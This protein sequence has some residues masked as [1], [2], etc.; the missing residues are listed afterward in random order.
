MS[1]PGNRNPHLH[2]V[3]EINALGKKHGI[4]YH[5][6]V[7]EIQGFIISLHKGTRKHGRNSTNEGGLQFCI[8]FRNKQL[9]NGMYVRALRRMLSYIKYLDNKPD[10]TMYKPVNV[11]NRGNGNINNYQYTQTLKN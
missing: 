3:R 7:D 2:L 1:K 11:I 10:K 8:Q 9:K 5:E 6:Y 4:M